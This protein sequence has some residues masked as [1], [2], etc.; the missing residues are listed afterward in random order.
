MLASDTRGVGWGRILY[1]VKNLGGE[2]PLPRRLCKNNNNMLCKHRILKLYGLVF[3]LIPVP[4]Q[5]GE[6]WEQDYRYLYRLLD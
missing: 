5:S 2:R 1:K 3:S 4:P 6:A